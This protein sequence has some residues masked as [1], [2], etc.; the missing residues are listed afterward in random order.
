MLLFWLWLYVGLVV[1]VTGEQMMEMLQDDEYFCF[2]SHFTD[3]LNEMFFL[4][5]RSDWILYKQKNQ[6]VFSL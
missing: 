4:E 1:V 5:E 3:V 6:S 2:H